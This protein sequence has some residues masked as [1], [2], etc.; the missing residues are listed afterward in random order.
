MI[1]TILQR[2][3]RVDIFGTTST[4]KYLG[5]GS[6]PLLQEKG[7]D[8]GARH[9][10]CCVAVCRECSCP[11]KRSKRKKKNIQHFTS[12]LTQQTAS[13]KTSAA[14]IWQ[15][16][17]PSTTRGT[18]CPSVWEQTIQDGMCKRTLWCRTQKSEMKNENFN[19][20][21][22]EK[23]QRTTAG[24]IQRRRF[25]PLKK[26]K[27]IKD[28]LPPHLFRAANIYFLLSQLIYPF[29]FSISRNYLLYFHHLFSTYVKP[30]L[31]KS[32]HPCYAPLL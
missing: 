5:D 12:S 19:I 13:A 9:W 1:F 3:G 31:L 23:W 20:E 32:S 15:E 22:N 7:D 2:K 6:F 10:M 14:V 26:N 30:S 4:S 8:V 24:G 11:A 17:R 27:K 25:E 29:F 21:T 18:Q 16:G 28:H